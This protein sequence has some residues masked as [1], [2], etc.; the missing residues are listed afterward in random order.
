MAGTQVRCAS[1]TG[2][3][4][5]GENSRDAAASAAEGTRLAEASNRIR[6]GGR[7]IFHRSV[8]RRNVSYII[9]SR[10]P[11]GRRRYP[12]ATVFDRQYLIG[13]DLTGTFRERGR[14]DR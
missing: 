8:Q 6:C 1:V 12:T 11:F 5:T 7:H 3:M 2:P 14:R 10:R 4:S 13:Q 9:S